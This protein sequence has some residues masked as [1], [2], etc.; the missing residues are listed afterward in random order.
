MDCPNC[1]MRE[2]AMMQAVGALVGLPA[3]HDRLW[4]P[5]CGYVFDRPPAPMAPA[6]VAKVETGGKE[7]ARVPR[8][9]SVAK[10]ALGKLGGKSYQK[11][12]SK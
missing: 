3:E 5:A 2:M 1:A 9:T 10:R 6:K 8:G 12:G 11:G 7:E 4:C